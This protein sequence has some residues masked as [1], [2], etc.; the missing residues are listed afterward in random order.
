MTFACICAVLPKFVC[1]LAAMIQQKSGTA[2]SRPIFGL[3]LHAYCCSHAFHTISLSV[4]DFL[5]YQTSHLLL[6]LF[7]IKLQFFIFISSRRG[8]IL[9]VTALFIYVF[10]ASGTSASGTHLALNGPLGGAGSDATPTWEV[11]TCTISALLDQD[12][13]VPAARSEWKTIPN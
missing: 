7:C 2:R 10:A 5:A 1:E 3:M 9:A 6:L 11:W 13:S 8:L 12:T 4:Y